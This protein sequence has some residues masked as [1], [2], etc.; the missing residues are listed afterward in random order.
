[1][2]KVLVV[3]DNEMNRDMLKRRLNRRG[4][5]I[6]VAEH[7]KEAITIATKELPDIILMDMRMPIMDG[8]TATQKIKENKDISHIPIIGLSANAM[9]GDR[10]KAL[11]AGC[12]DYSTKPVNFEHLINTITRY[13][14][15]VA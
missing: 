3:E 4:Y 5:E 13:C 14:G 6:V 15:K 12:N 8:W 11:E 2:T 7:G 1:M 9:E 10:E